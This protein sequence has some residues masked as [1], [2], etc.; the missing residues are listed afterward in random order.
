MVM[1]CEWRD[2]RNMA[3]C[4]VMETCYCSSLCG[5]G[6]IAS[7]HLKTVV[8]N[9]AIPFLGRYPRIIG[10]LKRRFLIHDYCCTI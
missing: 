8:H 2:D 3:L 1:L 10:Q 5:H 6:Y 9:A 7:C 4:V